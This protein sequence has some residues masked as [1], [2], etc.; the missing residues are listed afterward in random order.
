MNI[1]EWLI[2]LAASVERRLH[3]NYVL[4]HDDG[5]HEISSHPK[6]YVIAQ[7]DIKGIGWNR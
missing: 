7:V 4:N 5:A 3:L 2:Y 1:V 6:S